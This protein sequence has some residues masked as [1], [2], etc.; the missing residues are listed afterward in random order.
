MTFEQWLLRQI[1]T[2]TLVGDLANDFQHDDRPLPISDTYED[3]LEF[4]SRACQKARCAF[5]TAWQEYQKSV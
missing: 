3:W 1:G 2:N 5:Q 4:F